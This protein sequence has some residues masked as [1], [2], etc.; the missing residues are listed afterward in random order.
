M[1]ADVIGSLAPA[2][3][4]LRV[5]L[6]VLAATI[7]VGGQLTVAGILPAVRKLGNDAPKAIARAFA[8]LQWPAFFVLV[9]TGIWNVSADGHQSSSWSAVLGAKIAI[10]VVAAVAVIAHTR[11]KTKAG[12]AAYGA[13]SAVCSI[14]AV[15]LGVALAG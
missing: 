14:V 5:S 6:H 3:T 9:L 7:W 12:I 8:Q 4:I 2:G 15:V 10:V 13:L 1:S 11:S